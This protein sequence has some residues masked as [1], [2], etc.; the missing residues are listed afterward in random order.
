LLAD[1]QMTHPAA[2]TPS[3]LHLVVSIPALNEERTIGKVITGIP[4]DLPGVATVEVVVVDDGSSDQTGSIARRC[5]AH[6]IRHDFSG[7]VGAAFARGLGFAIDRG[8]DLIA[9]ID[10]DGQF[11]PADVAALVAP[12]VSGEADLVTASRFL[13]PAL[14]PEMPW[15]KKWGNRQVSHLISRLTGHRYHDVSCGMR[16]YGRRAMFSLNLLGTYTHVH[17]VFLNLSFKGMN[18]VELPVRVRGEREHG[19]SRV[20]TNIPRYA[21]NILRIIVRAYRD[22]KPLRFFGAAALALAVLGSLFGGFLLVHYVS[23]GEFTPH[24][25]AGFTAAALL[26]LSLL[27]LQIG[28]IGDMMARHRIYLEELLYDQRRRHAGQK[29]IDAS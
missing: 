25:W 6:V 5:G 15:T 23:T 2:E 14:E 21:F 26:G 22:Y 11:N 19:E 7:G 13:D 1:P 16:C 9:T 18:I 28:V 27:L 24:K 10:A 8:A 29:R 3:G 12:V 20:A 17:E 4:R